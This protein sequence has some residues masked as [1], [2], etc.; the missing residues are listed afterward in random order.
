MC[1]IRATTAMFAELGMRRLTSVRVRGDGCVAYPVDGRVVWAVLA[2]RFLH[3]VHA[4]LD[5]LSGPRGVLRAAAGRFRT[6]ARP[7]DRF[8]VRQHSRRGIQLCAPDRHGDAG[9]VRRPAGQFRS[10]LAQC[11]NVVGRCAADGARGAAN[12]ISDRQSPAQGRPH[13]VA[14]ARSQ[15]E[16][17]R[18]PAAGAADRYAAARAGAGARSGTAAEGRRTA[19]P[20]TSAALP[21]ARPT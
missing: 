1:R 2:Q 13:A 12:R 20:D 18:E 10:A 15:F 7:P 8:A 3:R 19:R 6:L 9:T 11:E 14:G 17:I 21:E 16:P 5:R 4:D